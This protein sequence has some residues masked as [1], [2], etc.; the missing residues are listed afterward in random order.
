MNINILV[1]PI[2]T[3]KSY[4][5][6][7]NQNVYTFEVNSGANKKQIEKAVETKFDVE[8]T[9]VRVVNRLGKKKTFGAKRTMGKRSN[10]KK[11][12]VTLKSGQKIDIFEMK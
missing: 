4:A 5:Q 8:V 9:K 2:L 7:K 3:E 6:A 10:T 1:R 11:S 12:F